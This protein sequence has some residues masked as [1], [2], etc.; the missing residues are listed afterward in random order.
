M[1][2][3]KLPE[4]VSIADPEKLQQAILNI[5]RDVKVRG[6]AGSTN[7][8]AVRC[9]VDGLTLGHFYDLWE[10]LGDPACKAIE[11]VNPHDGG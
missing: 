3:F 7:L 11:K 4:G 9:D 1:I 6:R 2:D 8:R 10:A 5:A